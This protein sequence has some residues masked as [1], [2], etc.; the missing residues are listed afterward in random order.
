VLKCRGGRAAAVGCG[1]MGC[2]GPASLLY[3]SCARDEGCAAYYNETFANWSFCIATGSRRAPRAFLADE[4][5]CTA[6]ASEVLRRCE[7]GAFIG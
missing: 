3:P 6:S 2:R 4:S 7:A 5:I 1:A